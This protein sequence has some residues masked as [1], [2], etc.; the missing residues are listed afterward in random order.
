MIDHDAY[1][2]DY[3]ASTEQV[4]LE[5]LVPASFFLANAVQFRLFP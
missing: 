5:I 2:P 4:P 1:S 3:S